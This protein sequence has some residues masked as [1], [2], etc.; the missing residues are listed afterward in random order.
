MDTVFYSWQS[1]LPGTRSFIESTLAAAIQNLNRELAVEKA[2]RLD[3]DTKG[4]AGWP[5]IISEILS[6]IEACQVFVADITPING[7]K[8][9]DK[10]TPNP[11][12]LLELGFALGTGMRERRIICV[13][14][15]DYLPNG[16]LR[17]LPF[18]LRSRRPIPF[19]LNSKLRPPSHP[20]MQ[21]TERLLTISLEEAIDLVMSTADQEDDLSAI[22]ERYSLTVDSH[23]ILERLMD[24]AIDSGQMLPVHMDN[25]SLETIR[26]ELQLDTSLFVRELT[27]L[28]REGCIEYTAWNDQQ[29]CKMGH[30]GLLTA[31]AIRDKAD[32]DACYRDVAS[33]ICST[34][35][36]R[37]EQITIT[38]IAETL[39][40]PPV[41]VNA[42]LDDWES[43]ELIQVS[44]Y[45]GGGYNI[46]SVSP[47]L[48]DESVMNP[49]SGKPE[50]DAT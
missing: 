47:L 31:M 5:D 14:N 25:E 27:R 13:V 3:Q 50:H 37:G 19:S 21:E 8:A 46:W 49:T 22:Y 32:L 23:L 38:E 9:N 7:P 15:T 18:D 33:M 45:L 4:V 36:D 16:D 41:L 30:E 26:T 11:N 12:V 1:D 28:D 10:M 6:K 39:S 20:D 35:A 17:E 44:R 43:I 48:E 42:I 24:S 29:R 2:L 34:G 40:K